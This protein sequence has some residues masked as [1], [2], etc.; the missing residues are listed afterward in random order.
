MAA[1]YQPKGDG[2]EE[3]LHA[4][5]GVALMIVVAA[6]ALDAARPKPSLAAAMPVWKL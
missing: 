5:V 3:G 1:A 6:V 2:N 4:V